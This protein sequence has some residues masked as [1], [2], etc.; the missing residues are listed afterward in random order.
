M[1]TTSISLH[2]VVGENDAGIITLDG[3][4]FGTADYSRFKYGDVSVAKRYGAQLAESLVRHFG[5][6]DDDGQLV[7]SASAYKSLPTAAQAVADATADALARSGLD[8]QRGRV[9]RET[10]TE[11]DYGDMSLEERQH[12][13]NKNGLWV[14]DADF[15]GRHVVIVDDVR[16]SGSHERSI[17]AMF[18]KIPHRSL[19][20]VHVLKLNP[21]LALADPRIEHRMN[22][23]AVRTLDDLL[24]LT[25]LE[26]GHH[27]NARFVKFVLSQPASDV[28][29][30]AR[31][32]S[33]ELL[34][35]LHEGAISDGY[36]S[37]LTYADG[38]QAVDQ[39]YQRRHRKHPFIIAT[40]ALF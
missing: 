15:V 35:A 28:R 14:K 1:S 30:F 23:H 21:E 38:F 3:A 9:Y 36:P 6:I 16:I 8:V 27:L 25:K 33:P 22:H 31:R 12:W 11:G 34:D 37:M 32:L 18:D 29:R 5:S 24:T 26:T 7:I 13:M 4:P 20:L 39:E 10:L 40:R 17:T 19:A 2:E